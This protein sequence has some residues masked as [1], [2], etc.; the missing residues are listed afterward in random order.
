MNFACSYDA[1][2]GTVF[3]LVSSRSNK[4]RPRSKMYKVTHET[5]PNKVLWRFKPS[6]R[7]LHYLSC[8]PQQIIDQSS[9]LS[10]IQKR[11][12]LVSRNLDCGRNMGFSN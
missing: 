11:N 3:S 8:K 7:E 2:G 12:Q 6:F 4:Q 5:I 10:S 1:D 9:R